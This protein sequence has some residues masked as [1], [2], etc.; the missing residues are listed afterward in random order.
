LDLKEELNL[1]ELKI[2]KLT[3]ENSILEKTLEDQTGELMQL[4]AE[5]LVMFCM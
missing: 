1:A 3:N 5:I 2:Q 4:T